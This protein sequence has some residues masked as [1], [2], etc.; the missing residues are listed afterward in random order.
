MRDEPE[1]WTWPVDGHGVAKTLSKLTKPELVEYLNCLAVEF[2]HDTTKTILYEQAKEAKESKTVSLLKK[3]LQSPAD[4]M[5]RHT[6]LFLPP[7]NPLLNPI[8]EVWGW[9][10]NHIARHR[11]PGKD[12]F[13]KATTERLF[14]EG[15]DLANP[16]A[17]GESRLSNSNKYKYMWEAACGHTQD[18]INGLY[19]EIK[20]SK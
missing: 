11:P 14:N 5:K 4:S 18:H 10:K 8:E 19:E 1:D 9:A 16:A 13:S 12:A 3:L 15:L 2:D 17:N 7:Y 20:T 6:L